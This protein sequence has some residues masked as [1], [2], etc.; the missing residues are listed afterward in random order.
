MPHKYEIG[1]KAVILNDERDKV[2]FLTSKDH[3]GDEILTFPGGRMEEG[4]IIIT[5]LKRE[6]SEELNFVG[7]V[8]IEKILSANPRS[9]NQENGNGLMLITVLVSIKID[10]PKIE[11]EHLRW[12]W[13]GLD[14]LKGNLPIKVDG[15]ILDNEGYLEAAKVVLS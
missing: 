6:L 3:H 11:N 10:K 9:F 1:I 2:L 14:E 15:A 7:E 13:L 12:F 4:E 8:K 5:T